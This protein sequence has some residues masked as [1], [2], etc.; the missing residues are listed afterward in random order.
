MVKWSLVVSITC[1]V[2]DGAAC[3]LVSD[4]LSSEFSLIP[5]LSLA[6]QRPSVTLCGRF[7]S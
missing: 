5:S 4:S 1:Q 7:G 3:L 2:D 6:L